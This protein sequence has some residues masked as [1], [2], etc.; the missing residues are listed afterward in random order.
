MNRKAIEEFL[1]NGGEI[2]VS[3]DRASVNGTTISRK[4]LESLLNDGKIVFSH[5][6]NNFIKA[7]KG[8]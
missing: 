4:I 7:Y 5:K 8:A 6:P 2:I 1:K 3:R